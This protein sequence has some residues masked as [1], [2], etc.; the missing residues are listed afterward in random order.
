M[1]IPKF[2]NQ[3][4]K[5]PVYVPTIA[6]GVHHYTINMTNFT[7]QILPPPLPPTE[8]WGYG[9]IVDKNPL[10]N[11]LNSYFR[12][13]PGPTFEV[14][15]DT[16]VNVTWQNNITVPHMFAVDPTLHWADPNNIGMMLDPPF[17][18]Y[19][20]GFNGTTY[21]YPDGTYAPSAQDPVPLI[22]HLHGGEVHSTSDGHPEAWFTSASTAKYGMNYSSNSVYQPS[23]PTPGEAV[24]Y[25]PNQQ[26]PTT[27]W[28]HDHALGI[29]RIN[30]M[31][32]LAGFYLLRD[33]WEFTVDSITGQRPL[34]YDAY[35][36]PIVI[37]DRS[38]NIDGSMWFPK[39][40]LDI[41]A[42]PYWQPEF[43]GN[44]I[45]VNGKVW[46]NLN[47]EQALHRFR[48]L[49]GSNARFYTLWFQ[50][51]PANPL[52]NP[53]PLTFYQIGTDGGYLQSP[54]PL[55]RLTIAPGERADIIVDFRNLAPGDRV[56]IRNSA[57]APFPNGV[58]SDP[59]TVG[60]IMQFTVMGGFTGEITQ[61]TTIPMS[62]PNT[63]P[64]DV[65]GNLL[66]TPN[67]PSTTL[68]LIEK[69][70]PL[71]PTE[72][73][74]DGQ[75]W[76]AAISEMP[77]NGSTVDWIIVNPTADTHPIHLHLVQFQ[78]VSRQKF[79]VKKYLA[80]WFTDNGVDPMTMV[81]LPLTHPTVNVLNLNQYLKGKPKLPAAN[82]MGWKDTIQVNPGEVTII[83]IRFSPIDGSPDYPFDPTT[84]PGYVWHCHILDHEDN[85][86]MR[87][88]IVLP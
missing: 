18:S 66:L 74:L 80:Q 23:T 55:T 27:L 28:Y 65:A 75:K 88:Y 71:G 53:A 4:V 32:G 51:K 44:T 86:M 37:Q 6:N 82:E 22:P 2:V 10:T 68:T 40:G 58:T 26:P 17:P 72:I 38:F 50:V 78:L 69:M 5:P 61:P 85:E 52:L 21:Q 36:Y 49:D 11:E 12:F 54:V 14:M 25:Y 77:L 16:A 76:G 30:V 1:L 57:N 59:K 48:L 41:N 29:T 67:Q 9:G 83:R 45:M 81:G 7:Q 56:I 42:H 33:S 46:P 20:P 63:V 64:R 13:A 31:S 84:G 60:Q 15:R 70:G 8:V 87:P 47:V 34:P 39:I 62:L 3:L 79:D 24:F 73:F 19:P 35:E 43:F